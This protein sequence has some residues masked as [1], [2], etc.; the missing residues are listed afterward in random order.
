MD[1]NVIDVGY[2]MIDKV[3]D[4]THLKLQKMCYY[5]QAWHYTLLDK[6]LFDDYFEAWVHGPVSPELYKKYKSYGY[7]KLPQPEKSDLEHIRNFLEENIKSEQVVEWVIK[8]YGKESAK[9][10][11][12]Q[13]HSEIPWINAR[14]TSKTFSL[15]NNEITLEAMKEYYGQFVK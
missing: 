1:I 10:L 15:S 9:T 11:E 6:P 4:V 14:N 3:K 8:R 12:A 7:E 5:C 2:L 13:S